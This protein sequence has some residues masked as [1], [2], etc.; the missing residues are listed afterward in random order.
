MPY[1]PRAGESVPAEAD[2]ISILNLAPLLLQRLVVHVEVWSVVG[3]FCGVRLV[4][5]PRRRPQFESAEKC[6]VQRR[7]SRWWRCRIVAAVDLARG[8]RLQQMRELATFP[9]SRWW[10]RWFGDAARLE[11]QGSQAR[12]G[13]RAWLAQTSTTNSR[14]HVA[15]LLQPPPAYI[16]YLTAASSTPT[17]RL[18]SRCA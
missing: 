9:I 6:S 3:S 2:P 8:R 17:L 15:L 7:V 1:H 5:G 10:V 11:V 4:V 18:F 14:G 16:H 13:K 12:A